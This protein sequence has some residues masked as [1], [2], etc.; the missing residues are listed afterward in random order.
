MKNESY[1]IR[2]KYQSHNE[3]RNPKL[4]AEDPATGLP[5]VNGKEA[6]AEA[7]AQNGSD[8]YLFSFEWFAPNKDGIRAGHGSEKKALYPGA[9]GFAG[10]EELGRAMREAWAAFI[11]DGDPN[12]G[13]ACFEAAQVEWKPYRKDAPNTMVFDAEMECVEGQRVED[14][15]S[16]MP[17]F[18]EYPLLR[19]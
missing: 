4:A 5:A 10:P 7:F 8:A 19:G 3:R 14:V 6:S 2:R 17:L 9:Q 1:Q 13:N 12:Q 16:L 15:E 11:L 18:E